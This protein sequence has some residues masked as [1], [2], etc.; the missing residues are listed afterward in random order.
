MFC[1]AICRWRSESGST[2][3]IHFFLMPCLS[4]TICLTCAVIAFFCAKRERVVD[5][6]YQNGPFIFMILGVEAMAA[7]PAL[8]VCHVTCNVWGMRPVGWASMERRDRGED[9]EVA[10]APNSQD[11][12]GAAQAGRH[13]G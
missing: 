3:Y 7:V 11:Q 2:I 10:G 4:N 5:T 1:S 6:L 12:E 9:R 8:V 13:S